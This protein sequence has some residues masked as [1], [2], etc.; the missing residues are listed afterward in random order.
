MKLA[1]VIPTYNERTTLPT[2][3]EVIIKE[4]RKI[5]EKFFIIII[6]DASPDGTGEI[7]EQLNKKYDNITVIHRKSKLGIGSAYKEGFKIVLEHFDPDLIIQMDSDYSHDPM[8]IPQMIQRMNGY[9]IAIASR[10]VTGSSI[11]GW[12]F[13]RK[14][15]HSL[16]CALAGTCG[17]MKISDPTS[18]FR[19]FKKN[20]LNS[21]NF[22][23]ISSEGF[24]FQIEL[25]HRLWKMGYKIIEIPTRFVNRKEGKSKMGFS[26]AIQFMKICFCLLSK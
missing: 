21:V 13:H 16:A 8:E 22:S 15:I 3:I 17:H 26:E 18:G 25:L 12:S 19:I 10:H 11:I 5:T 7:A 4:L 20:V 14:M 2:L 23:E 6:D 1:I 24:A 9:D